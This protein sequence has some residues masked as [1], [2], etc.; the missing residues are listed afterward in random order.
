[1]PAR[2]TPGACR[3]HWAIPVMTSSPSSRACNS[4]SAPRRS[5]WTSAIP[6]MTAGTV[7]SISIT[8]ALCSMLSRWAR[9]MCRACAMTSRT[10]PSTPPRWPPMPRPRCVR[11]IGHPACPPTG[12]RTAHGRSSSMSPTRKPRASRRSTSSPRPGRRAGTLPRSTGPTRDGPTTP[13][14]CCPTSIS[15][16]TPTRPWFV[17]PTRSAF[18]CIC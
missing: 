10:P 6:F 16:R 12:S 3:G 14:R 8:A 7:S 18:R 11:S 15:P 9:T 2:S 13:D 1:M 5:S 4:I 17:S